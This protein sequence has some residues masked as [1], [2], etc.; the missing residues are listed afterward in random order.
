VASGSAAPAV[1]VVEQ[2][3]D[4]KRPACA[5]AAILL[6]FFGG[7]GGWAALVPLSG[8]AVAPA[9]VAPDGYRKTIQHLEGGIVA[10]IRVREGTVVE[11]GDVLVV[12]DDTRARAEYA[13][14]GA[15]LAAAQARGARLAAEQAGADEPAFPADLLAEAGQDPA[16]EQ[17]LRAERESRLARRQVLAD[18]IAVRDSQIAEA[19]SDLATSEGSLASI[20]RQLGL[21]D[22]EIAT[23]EDLLV[24][25]L[26]RK[27][28]LLALQ[29]T[30][31][32]L[33]GER[34]AAIG[35]AARTKELIGATAA[36]RA[37]LISG[38]AEEVAS[39]LAETRASI[40]ELQAAVRTA[41]DILE[42][43]TIR[44]PVAGEVVELRLRTV[45]GVIGPGEPMM[46]L[47]PRDE[48]LVI[49]ARVAPRDIDVVHPGLAADIRLLAFRTRYLTRIRGVVQTV[50]GDRLL[51]AKT[52]EPYYTAQIVIDTA[53]LRQQVPDIHLTA[54]MPAEA[55]IITGER[56]MFEYL[57]DPIRST[58]RRALRES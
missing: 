8:A 33:E 27:P 30:R 10:E 36:D 6:L 46:D 25:G 43:S 12:L 24:R 9:I 16:T 26:D 55:L 5:A 22:E 53:S 18:Q 54:G 57:I 17:L 35:N 58:F 38:R 50:S 13:K 19:N 39:G 40:N 32:E 31:A 20:D 2:T 15:K 47:V 45:G 44:A 52:G 3:A 48:P 37:A 7:L 1:S 14:T 42:R 4:F 29:R 51:D 28:R 11:A 23:V 49:E 56:T 41:R 21:I 34:N